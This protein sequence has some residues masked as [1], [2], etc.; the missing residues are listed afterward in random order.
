MDLLGV[1]GK[2]FWVV[3]TRADAD[4][5]TKQGVAAVWVRIG[6]NADITAWTP[7]KKAGDWGKLA[8]VINGT[9]AYLAFPAYMMVDKQARLAVSEVRAKLGSYGVTASEVSLPA[10]ASV[11]TMVAAGKTLDDLVFATQAQQSGQTSLT[12]VMADDLYIIAKND[13][14]IYLSQHDEPFAVRTSGDKHAWML[15]DRGAKN[16][17]AHY[18]NDAYRQQTSSIPS[19]E[20]M[21]NAITAL[22]SEA[23]RSAPRANLFDRTG[24]DDSGGL[25]LD[26]AQDD[27][28]RCVV[29]RDGDWT[30]RDEPGEGVFF[31][32][33]KLHPLPTPERGGTK[34]IRQWVGDLINVSEDDW[35]LVLA[36]MVCY[37]LEDCTPPHAFFLGES[38]SGKSTSTRVLR[39]L[40]EGDITKGS[41]MK[42]DEDD[43]AVVLSKSRI[44]MFNNVSGISGEMSDLL[45]QVFDG[46]DYE[47]R[48]LRTTSDTTTLKIQC[49]VLLNGIETG[50][51]RSDLKTR[52]LVF[53]LPSITNDKRIEE[54]DIDRRLLEAHP[55]VLGHLLTLT[56]MV[57]ARLDH[58]SL[59]ETPRAGE[60]ARILAAIDDLYGFERRNLGNY[61]TRIEELSESSLDDPLF[62]VLRNLCKK[63]GAWKADE[64]VWEYDKTIGDLQE[65]VNGVFIDKFIRSQGAVPKKEFASTESLGAAMKRGAT[66][67]RKLGL[68]FKKH[69]PTRNGVKQTAY[70]I[71]YKPSQ[72]E[73]GETGSV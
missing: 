19:S 39:F 24:T 55:Y 20:A 43:V 38:D 14:N 60:Y 44:A 36:W 58:V 45:C 63:Y 72:D 13:F 48:T 51:L 46:M 2:K 54:R 17:I 33:G 8:S 11:E 23:M 3:G 22:V 70:V 50:R 10:G 62:R 18:L 59:A 15:I 41:K 5:V 52:I 25:W 68:T 34:S 16:D 32:R 73:L 7:A 6:A 1:Q 66:D 71:S 28:S 27:T 9:H 64:G 67:W 4:A 42:Q 69:R 40:L 21:N 35:S 47:K 37:L 29:I 65:E 57:R 26:L 12:G 56:A 53:E 31:R 61:M 49:A 30:L